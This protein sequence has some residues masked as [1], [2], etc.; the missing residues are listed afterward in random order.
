[1]RQH[2]LNFRSKVYATHCAYTTINNHFPAEVEVEKMN[3]FF[4]GKRPFTFVRCSNVHSRN[5]L[6]IPLA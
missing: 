5:L 3:N 6:E 1:M 2:D 4:W